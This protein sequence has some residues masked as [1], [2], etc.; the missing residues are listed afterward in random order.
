MEHKTPADGYIWL[1]CPF[2]TKGFATRLRC[3][4]IRDCVQTKCATLDCPLCLACKSRL[5]LRRCPLHRLKRCAI[6]LRPKEYTCHH[7]AANVTCTYRAVTPSNE[8]RAFPHGLLKV[9]H[10]SNTR[11][12]IRMVE[13]CDDGTLQYCST[14]F[15]R[16]D[17][18]QSDNSSLDI[19]VDAVQGSSEDRTGKETT[20][21]DTSLCNAHLTTFLQHRQRS[22]S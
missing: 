2:G 7:F 14:S 6:S 15:C 20:S 10:T 9:L 16:T 22:A 13:C 11:N 19:C 1:A 21:V 17:E 5:W 8:C 4:S 3:L 12:S 18:C